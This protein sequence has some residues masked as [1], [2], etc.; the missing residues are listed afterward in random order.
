MSVNKSIQLGLCCIN[1]ELRSRK[2]AIFMSRSC[3]L[4]TV[5]EKGLSIVKQ[6]SL[7]NVRDILKMIEWNEANGIKV[8]R[9]SSNIFPHYSNSQIERYDLDFIKDELLEV[10]NL[11]KKYNMRLTFHPGQYDVIGTPSHNVLQNTIL[12]LECHC[13][14]LDMMGMGVDSVVVIHG[15]GLYGD[16]GQ[17]KERWVENYNKLPDKI[18]RRLVLENC[19]KCFHIDDCLELSNILNIPVVFDTHHYTCYKQLHPIESFKTEDYYIKAILNTWTRKGIKPKFHVSEQGCGRIGHHSDY[20]NTIPEY[21][22]EIPR[23]YGIAIDIMI[24]AKMK[25]LSI[26]QLYKKYPYLNCRQN[27]N[28]IL[29]DIDIKINLNII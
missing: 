12:D 26:A 27:S 13:N 20:I 14:I 23:K 8:L 9:L 29:T 5:R 1:T 22:L 28:E 4:K 24:E 21:L 10:G 19:E 2:P 25:E 16:K 3:T 17:T 18:K 7:E 15:G 6:K 11:A